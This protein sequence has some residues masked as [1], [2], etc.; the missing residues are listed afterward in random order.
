MRLKSKINPIVLLENRK[1]QGKW[2]CDKAAKPSAKKP[3][4]VGWKPPHCPAA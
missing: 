4:G 2:P 1:K 3:K